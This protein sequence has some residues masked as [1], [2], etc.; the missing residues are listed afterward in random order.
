MQSQD[1]FMPMPGQ[2]GSGYLVA[3][4]RE[5]RR[6]GHGDVIDG[7]VAPRTRHLNFGIMPSPASG[8]QTRPG[9][10]GDPIRDAAHVIGMLGDR[11]LAS[12]VLAAHQRLN[13]GPPVASSPELLGRVGAYVTRSTLGA[14]TALAGWY[15]TPF[16]ALDPEGTDYRQIGTLSLLESAAETLVNEGQF[17]TSGSVATYAASTWTVDASAETGLS[18]GYRITVSNPALT[19]AVSDLNY[20]STGFTGRAGQIQ[21]RNFTA[22]V[23]RPSFDLYVPFAYGDR[24]AGMADG[25][26]QINTD[27]SI[28][29]EVAITG[30]DSGVSPAYKLSVRRLTG[31]TATLDAILAVARAEMARR[32]GARQ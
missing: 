29:A 26:I 1:A 22:T 4:I 3:M 19:W 30:L 2:D 6:L 17:E 13:G 15:A 21:D 28:T 8:V 25:V 5:L 12:V 11:R 7:R 32:R 18:L 20:E 14:G 9:S 16:G 31:G 27:R 24:A 23:K 10:R